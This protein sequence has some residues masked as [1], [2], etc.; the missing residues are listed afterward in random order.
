MTKKIN[1]NVQSRTTKKKQNKHFK[2]YKNIEYG[3]LSPVD[4][5]TC[6]N[7]LRNQIR[8]QFARSSYYYIFLESKK[9]VVKEKRISSNFKVSYVK[10]VYWECECCN[11]D[12]SKSDINVDHKEPIGS[13]VLNAIEDIYEYWKLVY[14]SYDNLQIL[15]KGC[16]IDKTKR[17]QEAPSY[18]NATF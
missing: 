11:K 15:C 3:D 13:G 10:R 18:K 4:I 8:L 14:C 12:F 1:Q 5:N 2:R 7:A 6:K 16:H 17:E 9:K